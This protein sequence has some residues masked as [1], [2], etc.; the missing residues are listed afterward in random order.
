MCVARDL[1]ELWG[2]GENAADK[3]RFPVTDGLSGARRSGIHYLYDGPLGRPEESGWDCKSGTVSI[4]SALLFIP[5]GSA[6]A[7]RKVLTDCQMARLATEK[8][9]TDGGVKELG[10]QPVIEE[11]SPQAYLVYQAKKV[12]MPIGETTVILNEYLRNHSKPL[13]SWSSVR[14]FIAS[15]ECMK[16]GKRG[17]RVRDAGR[18]SSDEAA[19]DARGRHKGPGRQGPQAQADRNP[20]RRTRPTRPEPHFSLVS[21]VI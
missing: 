13:V 11:Y 15:S 16:L 19:G 17:G 20:R 1:Y 4:I 10:R 21:L 18:I 2:S 7:V 6:A 5:S 14:R 12:G 9:Y 8:Y 3:S